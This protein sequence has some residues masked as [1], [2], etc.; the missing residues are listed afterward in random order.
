MMEAVYSCSSDYPFGERRRSLKRCS[1][2]VA[3][4]YLKSIFERGRHLLAQ[5]YSEDGVL[6]YRAR[7]IRASLGRNPPLH[8]R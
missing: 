5:V 1:D 6:S 8:R 7:G 3:G 2:A 4:T